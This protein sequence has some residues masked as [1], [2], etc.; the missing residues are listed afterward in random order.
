M[1]GTFPRG[2]FPKVF[3]RWQL[4]KYAISQAATSQVCS[5]RIARPL[6][7]YS[8]STWPLAPSSHSARPQLQPVAP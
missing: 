8:R 3:S 4:S 1:L 2:N 6:A 7:Y 5:S